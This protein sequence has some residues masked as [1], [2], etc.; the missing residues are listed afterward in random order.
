MYKQ[1]LALHSCNPF[2]SI[3]KSS[4]CFATFR[5]LQQPF[6]S[7]I[8]TFITG[9]ICTLEPTLL[10][11]ALKASRASNRIESIK[12]IQSGFRHTRSRSRARHTIGA[13]N[14]GIGGS[15]KLCLFS[16]GQR[17]FPI[18]KLTPEC[19]ISFVLLLGFFVALVLLVSIGSID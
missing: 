14:R 4:V 18:L 9:N 5:A 11:P 2:K 10:C 6:Y 15:F 16:S 1:F 13:S 19:P 3:S 7:Y 17:G 8:N 12:R